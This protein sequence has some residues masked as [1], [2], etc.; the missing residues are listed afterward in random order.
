MLPLWRPESR[1]HFPCPVHVVRDSPSFVPFST[2]R[3]SLIAIN[4][5][6]WAMN[7]PSLVYE[8]ATLAKSYIVQV[9]FPIPSIS[10]TPFPFCSI[11]IF[12]RNHI[13]LP[14]QEASP[15]S[16]AAASDLKTSALNFRNAASI[17]FL[18]SGSLI[19]ALL[20]E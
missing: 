13:L 16:N 8:T 14:V 1:C 3:M 18:L 6:K 11:I 4:G 17:L 5:S 12:P 2:V 9:L 7:L 10:E 15:F 19:M 20:A